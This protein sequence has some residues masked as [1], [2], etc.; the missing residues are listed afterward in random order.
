MH[1]RLSDILPSRE[2]AG[3]D[4]G[5]AETDVVLAGD[6]EMSPVASKSMRE[7]FAQVEQ[8]KNTI[9]YVKSRT[10]EVNR[11]Q[12]EAV[13][14]V[15]TADQQQTSEDLDRV[16]TDVNKRCAEAKQMLTAM[17]AE[18]DSLEKKSTAPASELRIRK[19]M[20]NSTTQNF[21]NAVRAFQQAQQ[22]YK[23]K[24]KEKSARQIRYV[25]PDATYE[26]IDAVM[27]S[28]DPNAVYRAAI[29]N[30]GNDAV[31][32]TFMDVQAKYQDVLRL[33]ESVRALHQMFQD[34]ALLVE[35]QG[36]MLDQIEISVNQTVEHVDKGKQELKK[37][38]KA[39]KSIRKK[40]FILAIIV[41]IIIVVIVLVVIRP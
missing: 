35:T 41:I 18:T 17:K 27:K 9:T 14:A 16:L 12:D 3:E 10:S 26:E 20:Y 1:S 4:N 34:L 13:N 33:E 24:M 37:A 38:L 5:A 15:L 22:T 30:Q 21:V 8:L 11:L 36:E 19:N 2:E 32:Q 23:N 28:G 40:Y 6:V 29:L 31:A 7:F 25:K 39:R